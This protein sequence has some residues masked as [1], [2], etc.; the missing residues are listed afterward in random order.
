VIVDFQDLRTS[1]VAPEDPFL[2]FND[3]PLLEGMLAEYDYG[4]ATDSSTPAEDR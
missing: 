3:L 1:P 2:D 4:L